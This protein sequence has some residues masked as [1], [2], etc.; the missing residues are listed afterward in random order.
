MTA[1]AYKKAKSNVPL[2]QKLGTLMTSQELERA[3]EELIAKHYKR[4]K[5]K[6][7]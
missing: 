7:F 1:V 3:V 5:K 6:I 4:D 2:D